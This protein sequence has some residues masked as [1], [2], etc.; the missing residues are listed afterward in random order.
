MD[1]NHDELIM[2][3]IKNCSLY[4]G[5]C[6][7][8]APDQVN[9]VGRPIDKTFEKKRKYWYDTMLSHPKIKFLGQ[10]VVQDGFTVCRRVIVENQGLFFQWA[11]EACPVFPGFQN[12][13]VETFTIMGAEKISISLF[14]NGIRSVTSAAFL[15]P[16]HFWFCFCY[17]I[18]LLSTFG[19][20]CISTKAKTKSTHGAFQQSNIAEVRKI[21]FIKVHPIGIKS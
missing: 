16:G 18:F 15:D 14:E 4:G 2:K 1:L 6:R 7:F 12:G 10:G 19:N 21:F 17:H 13:K 11:V 5:G 8:E 3:E 9:L 20:N